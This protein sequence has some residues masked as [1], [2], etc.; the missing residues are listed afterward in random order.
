MKT[1]WVE[2]KK[3]EF[4]TSLKK[5]NKKGWNIPH[6]TILDELEALITQTQQ[7]T[8]E[9]VK[10]WADEWGSGVSHKSLTKNLETIKKRMGG[11]E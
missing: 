11:E 7:E 3:K 2:E 8:L 6:G 10:K 9:E 1:K 5:L 4:E